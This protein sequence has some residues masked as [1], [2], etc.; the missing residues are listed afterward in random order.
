[1]R[2]LQRGSTGSLYSQGGSW[3]TRRALQAP[4]EQGLAEGATDRQAEGP[5]VGLL[6]DSTVKKNCILSDSQGVIH[7]TSACYTQRKEEAPPV[8]GATIESTVRLLDQFNSAAHQL[9]ITIGPTLGDGCL[10]P[11]LK[12]R[13]SFVDGF[14]IRQHLPSSSSTA[15]CFCYTQQHWEAPPVFSCP[16]L[17]PLLNHFEPDASAAASFTNNIKAGIF[18]DFSG[19]LEPEP[20]EKSWCESCGAIG[21]VLY[22]PRALHS[23]PG[24]TPSNRIPG[25]CRV[26]C[27]PVGQLNVHLGVG[28]KRLP[29]DGA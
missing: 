17:I 16:H 13:V 2:R 8:S 12:H 18:I 25:F 28:V 6:C 5:D 10:A 3:S 24:C 26:L 15:C 9:R 29:S 1:M 11:P 7:S 19:I 14:A 4:R 21:F 23:R 22:Q 27:Q 20:A